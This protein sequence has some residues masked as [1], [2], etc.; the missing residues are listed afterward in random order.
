MHDHSEDYLVEVLEVFVVERDCSQEMDQL[1]GYAHPCQHHEGLLP[2]L[3]EHQHSVDSLCCFL[4]E[5]C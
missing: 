4:E 1:A 5:V 3:G 2:E